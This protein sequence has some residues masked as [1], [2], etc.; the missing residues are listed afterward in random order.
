[1]GHQKTTQYVQGGFTALLGIVLFFLT[2][3]NNK[4]VDTV[5]LY[6]FGHAIPDIKSLE[7]AYTATPTAASSAIALKAL[8]GLSKKCLFRV[9]GQ[10]NLRSPACQC[11]FDVLIRYATVPESIKPLTGWKNATLEE[12]YKFA[13]GA[14]KACFDS[15]Q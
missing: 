9:F 7:T 1:M 5:T 11:A 4:G 13:D 6:S 8:T 2:A 15:Q 12:R 3:T 10:Q 14:I